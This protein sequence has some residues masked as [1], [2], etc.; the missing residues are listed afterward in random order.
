MVV[1]WVSLNTMSMRVPK[2]EVVFESLL[3]P[4]WSIIGFSLVLADCYVECS[5][6]NPN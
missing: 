3:V 1:I 4:K 2:S 5:L 6:F